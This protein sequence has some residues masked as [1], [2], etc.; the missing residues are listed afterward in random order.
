MSRPTS[1]GLLQYRI[2]QNKLQVFLVF[3]GG[4][5]YRNKDL[6]AWTIPKGHV[7]KGENEFKA[8]QR[9]FAEE[10]GAKPKLK[11]VIELGRASSKNKNFVMW[12]FEGKQSFIKSNTFTMEWPKGS[13]KKIEVPENDKGKFFDIPTALRKIN[14]NQSVFITNLVKELKNPNFGIKKDVK[15]TKMEKYRL[16]VAAQPKAI[17]KKMV[18]NFFKEFG[19]E[20]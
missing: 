19:K 3:P 9:E 10:V 13:G 8:A 12:A 16:L 11:N 4:P 17:K 1:A 14:R 7:E 5:F 2:H 20:L 18:Y 15:E 6:G